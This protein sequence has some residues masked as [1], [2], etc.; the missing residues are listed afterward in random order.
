MIK[1]ATLLVLSASV[2]AAGCAK[3]PEEQELRKSG[4]KVSSASGQGR[5]I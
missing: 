4:D 5:V 2:L 3:S 1:V